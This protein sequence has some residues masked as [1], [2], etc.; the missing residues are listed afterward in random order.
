[1]TLMT[2]EMALNA[3][4]RAKARFFVAKRKRALLF[5]LRAHQSFEGIVV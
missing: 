3:K 4:N 1:M 2:A 5:R